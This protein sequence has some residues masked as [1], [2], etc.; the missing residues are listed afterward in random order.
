LII[1][2]T[3]KVN[4]FIYYLKSNYNLSV[5]ISEKKN[6]DN[7]YNIF[8]Y[9]TFDISK[10]TK[11]LDLKKIFQSIGL[12]TDIYISGVGTVPYNVKLSD[13]KKY[14]KN[15]KKKNTINARLDIV[16]SL[17]KNSNYSEKD[18]S[19]RYLSKLLPLIKIDN[20]GKLKKILKIIKN[21]NI[22]FYKKILE[23]IENFKEN[24]K[25]LLNL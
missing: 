24:N 6:K 2:N 15:W 1:N 25:N 12:K 5:K 23:T 20:L 11:I 9:K 18:W 22:N 16:L 19:L 3:T 21:E 17:F 7:L 8:F 10:E 14:E 13:I 4:Q